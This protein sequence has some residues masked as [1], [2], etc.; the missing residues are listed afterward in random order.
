MPIVFMAPMRATQ[1][2]LKMRYPSRLGP[3][4]TGKPLRY[5]NL[6]QALMARFAANV[7]F[8]RLA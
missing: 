2:T 4:Q 5:T 8:D 6:A 7:L 1:L 3:A